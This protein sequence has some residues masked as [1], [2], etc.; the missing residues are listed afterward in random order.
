MV[1]HTVNQ[2]IG[3]QAM[4]LCLRFASPQDVI[5]LLEDGVYHAVA[6]SP[7]YATLLASHPGPIVAIRDDLEVRGLLGQLASG[8]EAVDYHRFVALCGECDNIQSWF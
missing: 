2:P 3:S 1:L 4:Q 6:D 7:A 8:I 5:L